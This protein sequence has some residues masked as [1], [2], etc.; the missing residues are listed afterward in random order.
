[1]QIALKAAVGQAKT[2]GLI[3]A[4]PR[5]SSVPLDTICNAAPVAAELANNVAQH[6]PHALSIL[7]SRLNDFIDLCQIETC[8][9][10]FAN[11]TQFAAVNNKFVLVQAG[12]KEGQ[13]EMQVAQ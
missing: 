9:N 2:G 5:V 8:H 10:C 3:S 12:K 6:G 1:M 7:F 4:V 13:E 11:F